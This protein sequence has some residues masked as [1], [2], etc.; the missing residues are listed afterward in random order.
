MV[1][2]RAR[3]WSPVRRESGGLFEHEL[4]SGFTAHLFP[5]PLRP[6]S[7]GAQRMNSHRNHPR[8]LRLSSLHDL[9]IGTAPI[10]EQVLIF[11]IPPALRCILSLPS[12]RSRPCSCPFSDSYPSWHWTP[13]QLSC[14]QNS[15]NLANNSGNDFLAAMS[16]W[17]CSMKHG[18]SMSGAKNKSHS[19]SKGCSRALCD[20]ERIC[21]T[22]NASAS[23]V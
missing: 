20:T 19:A 10:T 15:D 23:C 5:P 18:G 13:T 21:A 4:G 8:S 3:R 17:I 9:T 7:L 1:E 22:A 14:L 11:I 12:S 6:A 16:L 2:A